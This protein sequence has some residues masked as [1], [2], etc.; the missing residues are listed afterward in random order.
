MF[1]NYEY[2]VNDQFSLP[3]ERNR[4]AFAVRT[5]SARKKL[6]RT[7]GHIFS[8]SAMS[9]FGFAFLKLDS[10]MAFQYAIIESTMATRSETLRDGLGFFIAAP[11]LDTAMSPAFILNLASGPVEAHLL[12]PSYLSE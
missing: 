4:S 2:F 3:S 1:A 9:A 6:L 11:P 10:A 5:V 7:F 8:N 12:R